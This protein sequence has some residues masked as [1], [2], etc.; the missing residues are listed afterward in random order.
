MRWVKSAPICQRLAPGEGIGPLTATAFVAALAP[1]ALFKKGG[2]VSA[3]LGWGP[4]QAST[5]GKP[6][7]LG[8]RKRED[9]SRRSLLLHGAR[10]GLR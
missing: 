7:L 5:G 1:P 2:Q 9:G 3:W 10:A 6:V 8:I 4:R